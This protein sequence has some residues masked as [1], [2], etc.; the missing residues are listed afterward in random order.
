M[1]MPA[2]VIICSSVLLLCRESTPVTG[3]P[4]PPAIPA[5]IAPDMSDAVPLI[6]HDI[7]FSENSLSLNIQYANMIY[8]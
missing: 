1:L 2:L 7:I 8:R 5:A 6:A 4:T 3:V